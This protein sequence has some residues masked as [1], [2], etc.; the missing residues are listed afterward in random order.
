MKRTK[1]LR[2]IGRIFKVEE[3]DIPKTLERFK[4]EVD[5]M[6]KILKSYE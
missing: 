6:E 2:E 1:I 4:K 5:E 3:K